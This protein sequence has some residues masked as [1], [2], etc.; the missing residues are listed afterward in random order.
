MRSDDILWNR[1]TSD[2]IRYTQ[3]RSYEIIYEMIKLNHMITPSIQQL[4]DMI[5]LCGYHLF[6]G[7]PKVPA[8][9]LGYSNLWSRSRRYLD[10][11]FWATCNLGIHYYIL[12]HVL[13]LK[14]AVT[15][16]L[17]HRLLVKP[18]PKLVGTEECILAL[19]NGRSLSFKTRYICHSIWVRV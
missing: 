9:L 8:R 4:W 18:L 3:M 14:I 17:F 11:R 15:F 10:L 6:F 12:D 2:E 5:S 19:L 7:E 13:K 16:S 1:M